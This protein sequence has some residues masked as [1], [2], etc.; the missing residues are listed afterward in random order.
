[1]VNTERKS[2]L[3]T[4]ATTLELGRLESVTWALMYARFDGG[5]SEGK[6]GVVAQ[7]RSEV[8]VGGVISA[9]PTG[10]VDIA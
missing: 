3:G 10:H 9:R 2:A 7:M 1:M 4:P 6:E 8:E 5:E